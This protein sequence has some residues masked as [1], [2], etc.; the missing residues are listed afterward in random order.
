LNDLN[1]IPKLIATDAGFGRVDLKA[2]TQDFTA[3]TTGTLQAI[4]LV[5]N[6]LKRLSGGLTTLF[7][8]RVIILNVLIQTTFMLA[9]TKPIVK[10]LLFVEL[11]LSR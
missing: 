3:N 8:I 9:P 4:D 2:N 11:D 6:T 10:T 5:Q 7:A 1:P